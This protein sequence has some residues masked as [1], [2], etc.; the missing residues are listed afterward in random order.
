M[1]VLH[2]LERI[3]GQVCDQRAKWGKQQQDDNRSRKDEVEERRRLRV[4][5]ARQMMPE[6]MGLRC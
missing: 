2:W 3:E 5:L 1:A 6:P 4:K